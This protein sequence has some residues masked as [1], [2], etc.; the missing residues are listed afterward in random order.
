MVL[1]AVRQ[2]GYELQYASDDLQSDREVVLAAVRTDGYALNPPPTISSPTASGPCRHSAEW[3]IA[4]P[5]LR[6]A[7]VRPRGGPCRGSAVWICTKVRLRRPQVRPRG[8]PAAVRQNGYA[9]KYASDDLKSD[10]E[11]VFATIRSMHMEY[12]SDD[13]KSDR[14]VVLAAVRQNGFA[15]EYA[16]DDLGRMKVV[17]IAVRK[18]G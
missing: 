13:L 10:R 5:R 17:L 7:Q 2:N 9:L 4:A 15:L 18:N 8:G 11:V 16:S 6:R 12:A 1:A 14:E 3:R